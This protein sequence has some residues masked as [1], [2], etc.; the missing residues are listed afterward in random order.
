MTPKITLAMIVRDEADMAEA[1][2]ES[3]KGLYDELV[4]VDTGS[5]DCTVERFTAGG[6]TIVHHAWRN[7]FADARNVSL[8]HAHGDWVVV[9]DADERGTPEFV[10]RV[11]A[12][13]ADNTI[14][15][16]TFRISNPL[17]YGHRRDSS[18]LRAF[19]RDAAVQFRHAIHEDASSD[20]AMMLARTGTTLTSVDEPVEHLGYVRTRAA[21]KD[22]KSRDLAL[23]GVC[24]EQNEFDF[25]SRLKVL[26]LARYWR[27][28]VL[29]RDAASASIDA[30]HEAGH[31][32]L[33]GLPWAG[34]FVALIAEGLFAPES[35]KSLVFL[36]SFEHTISHS[37]A[38]F[39]R[40]A[41]CH[42]AQSHLNEAR[43]DFE[44]CLTLGEVL[45]DQQLTTVRPLL[46]LARL[47]LMRGDSTQAR[48]RSLEALDCVP[49]DPEALLAVASLTLHLDGKAGIDKWVEAH[50]ACVGACPE[51]DWA[52]GEAAFAFGDARLALS[53]LRQAAGVPP[54]GA[55][56]V[57]L[58]QVCLALGDFATSERLARM[59]MLSE[60]EAGLG[61]LLFDLIAGRDTDIELELTPETAQASM[62]HW[63][64]SLL[65]SQNEGLVKTLSANVTAIDGLFPWLPQYLV[66]ASAS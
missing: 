48:A 36:D 61:V 52:I 7:D 3:F 9:L 21:A 38:F 10:A 14:G 57:R 31:A 2:L 49:R 47:A 1:F 27:D 24:I 15:A 25:Y 45:G 66:R 60:P 58:A 28:G 11:R 16:L 30:L 40:R 51:R 29:W 50:S 37:A 26:E 23:L 39:H 22:K 18:V 46:G 63:V 33:A 55:A 13:V 8:A 17:P 35:D 42:E 59:L 62:R 65:M 20:V 54:S 56:G 41:Q 6:A 34:E 4:V 12:L 32:A 5:V 64:D 43:A 44:K 19:R 53:S